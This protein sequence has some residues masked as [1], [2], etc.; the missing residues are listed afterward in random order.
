MKK[1]VFAFGI[2][3]WMTS[4]L[5]VVA[6]D[7][8][9]KDNVKVI[10]GVKIQIH[11][12]NYKAQK[13]KDG[14][15]ITFDLVIKNGADSVLQDTRKDGQP[16]KGMIQPPNATKGAFKGTFE[17]GLRL[18]SVG[19]LATILVPINSLKKTVQGPLPRFLK[20]GTDLKYT[21]KILKVQSKA[22]FEKEM[23]AK[24]SADKKI[25]AKQTSQEPVLIA[26]FITET[27]KKFEKTASGLYYSIEN[28]GSGLSP[29]I[30]ETWVVNYRGTFMDGEEFDKG[31]DVEMPLG[32]MI[33]GFNEAL[34]LMK[35]GGK[36][37]FVLPSTIGYGYQSRGPIPA[38]SVLVFE[39]E[40][41]SKK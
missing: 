14:D 33:Q 26:A 36:A 24:N 7:K 8:K 25:A 17:N 11:Q 27:G 18:L 5:N 9:S 6:Q 32:Q 2:I 29:Q 15:I 40:V 35:A 22:E 3:L 34:T 30:G 13:L 12:H 41:I 10:D 23:E 28:P 31:T 38:N 21:V 19:D 39:I 4:Y 1:V 16:G 20:P 37:T